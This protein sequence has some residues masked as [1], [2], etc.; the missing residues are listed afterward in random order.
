MCRGLVSEHDGCALELAVIEG[1]CGRVR[2]C[3]SQH[4]DYG[5]SR[6]LVDAA[7][8]HHKIPHSPTRTRWD[9]SVELY[10]AVQNPDR[11]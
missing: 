10:I 5:M 11:R 8:V 1:P 2:R 3:C 9:R 7:E 6:P 4:F